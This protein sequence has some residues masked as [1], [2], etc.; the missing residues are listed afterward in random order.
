MHV[1]I[2]YTAADVLPFLCCWEPGPALLP[3][4]ADDADDGGVGVEDVA[5]FPV[6]PA[7]PPDAPPAAD[8]GGLFFFFFFV[9]G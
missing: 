4:A 9:L 1:N 5:L 6:A 3:A 7:V 2:F 8:E